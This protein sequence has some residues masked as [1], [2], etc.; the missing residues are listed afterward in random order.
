MIKD[1]SKAIYCFYNSG[2][3][4]GN[5]D[6]HINNHCNQNDKNS[7]Y[8]KD[9]YE[10]QDSSLFV[11]TGGPD[12]ENHF[13]VSDYEVFGIDYENR[14]NINKLCKHPDIIWECIETKDISEESLS[15]LKEDRELLNDMNII[16][17]INSHVLLKISQYY[18]KSPSSY[19]PN[20]HIVS[21]QYDSYLKE[22]LGKNTTWRLLYRAS[23]HDY[24]GT[25]FHECCNNKGPTLV[26]IKST[27]GWIFGGFTNEDWIDSSIFV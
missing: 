12:E 25:S 23:E 14:D 27:E 4:F 20:T 15:Q 18:L 8:C 10:F 26:I 2:P 21:Q 22:W 19:L 11:N 24:T 7:I 17:N 6:I 1:N 13:I 3:Y 9:T 5:G 16:H